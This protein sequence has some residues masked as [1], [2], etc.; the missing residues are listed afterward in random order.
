MNSMPNKKA[1]AKIMTEKTG[2]TENECSKAIDAMFE[3]ITILLQKEGAVCFQ[4]FGTFRKM[5]VNS[6]QQRNPQTGEM[7]TLPSK[8]RVR[9]SACTALKNS[10]NQR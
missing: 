2:L 7:M 4:K 5:H 9:F 10:V 8:N 6:R 3:A 1:V